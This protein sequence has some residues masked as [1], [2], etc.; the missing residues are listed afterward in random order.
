MPFSVQ[1]F[2]SNL[3]GGGARPNLFEVVVPFPG[4][5]ND[6]GTA[7]QKF[8]FMC[9]AAQLPGSDF[10]T[11]EVPYFG[12]MIKYA[13]NRT[14]AE[15]AT[16]VINDED[17]K[18]HSGIVNWMNLINGH[19]SNKRNVQNTTDYQVDAIVNQYGKTG[20]VIKSV[21][22]VNLWPQSLAAMD[23]AWE[24]NDAFE[25][26]GVTWMYDYWKIEDSDAQTV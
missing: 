8:T 16:T 9:K 10:G 4:G 13:G 25:E 14:F 24:S 6:G 2:R 3:T 19:T 15:W 23:L 18:V 7:S 20:E 26:F 22:F 11:V 21:T 5:V 17:F 12:R 1:D